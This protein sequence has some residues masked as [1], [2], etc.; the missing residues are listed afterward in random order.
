MS[1]LTGSLSREPWLFGL[2]QFLNLQSLQ[3]FTNASDKAKHQ[4]RTHKDEKDYGCPVFQCSKRY[5]DPSSLRKHVFHEHGET[6]WTFAKANKER[7]KAKDYGLIG[8]RPDGTPYALV[9]FLW[10][11]FF[12][13]DF[14][15]FFLIFLSKN[16]K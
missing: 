7:K 12:K 5:T 11:I 8:I 3:T 14:D 4:N 13:W 16:E 15:N 10:E 1:I 9:D 2:F 6:V